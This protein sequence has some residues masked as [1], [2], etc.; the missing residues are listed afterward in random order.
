[1]ARVGSA[2]ITEDEYNDRVMH[3][4]ATQFPQGVSI[5]AGGVALVGMIHEDL[6]GQL[7]AKKNV[8]PSED[9]LL[10]VASYYKRA[11]PNSQVSADDLVRGLRLNM[12]TFGIGTDGAKAD[13]KEV[14]DTYKKLSQTVPTQANGEEGLKVP[15]M[16]T[17]QLLP[18][19]TEAMATQALDQIK[20]N[21]PFPT[22][23]AQIMNVPVETA[24]SAGREQS[25]PVTQLPP[26]LKDAL[27]ST[28]DGQFLS[29]PV[30]IQQQNPQTGAMTT[31]YLVGKV[32]RKQPEYVP[33]MEDVRPII[34]QMLVTKTHPEW[35]T[36]EQSELADFTRDMA[37]N[38]EIQINIPRY[39]AL[40]ASFIL[41]MTA[42]HMTAPPG[43]AFSAPSAP[44][45]GA[46]PGAGT[47]PPSG[48]GA[49]PAGGAGTAAPS[50]GTKA[51]PAGAAG[52][53]PAGGGASPGIGIAPKSSGG[54]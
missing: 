9:S 8:V 43:S 26:T 16:I 52:A 25:Y 3:V 33:P 19:P 18:M 27:Q 35:Q 14:E 24:A 10:K 12:E 22:V 31:M 44:S 17:A 20:R 54:K 15:A 53:P 30:P 29:K 49:P 7:A 34:E 1:M 4:S 21:V 11:T 40:M 50:G 13:P 42:A 37:A 48:A 5:D 39:R 38:N 51:P 41:P 6:I 45:G 47:A 36:H 28:P 2:T 46:A 23:A 32:I